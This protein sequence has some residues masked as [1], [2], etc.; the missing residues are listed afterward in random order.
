MTILSLHRNSRASASGQALV[1]ACIGLALMALTWVLISHVC[2]MRINHVRT[3]M[4]ARHAAWMMGHNADAGGI[5]GSFFYGR[6]VNFAHIAAPEGLNLS[7]IGPGWSGADA[8]AQRAT[9]T[10]GITAE[11]FEKPDVYPF[12]LMKIQIPFMPS[13]ALTNYLSESSS[14]V[15]P[16]DVENTWPDRSDALKGVLSQI[17]GSVGTILEWI[18]SLLS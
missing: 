8:T 3:V 10:F 6:D 1:E 2:Y 9:V 11:E 16:A 7:A 13:L 14:A 4:A 17:A 5:A 15:W 12:A 18:G